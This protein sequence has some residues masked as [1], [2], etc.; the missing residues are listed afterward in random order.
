MGEWA[1]NKSWILLVLALVL[2]GG[3]AD[4]DTPVEP[5]PPTLDELVIAN[6]YAARDY[7]EAYADTWGR[8]PTFRGFPRY[9]NNPA[10]GNLS[11]PVDGFAVYPG[12]TG[13]IPY[14]DNSGAVGYLITSYG[15]TGEI[16][17]INKN[18]SD[19]RLALDRAILA[20]CLIV[21]SAIESFT[22]E[23]N[24]VYPAD[25]ALDVNLSGDT[26]RDLLPGGTLLDN[27]VTQLATEPVDIPTESPG[28][29]VYRST[30]RNGTIT[31]YIVSGWS[32]YDVVVWMREKNF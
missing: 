2:A 19:S 3:C 26:V 28:Q 24:G 16:F 9:L 1:M 8:Y 4:K 15:E 18:Y 30:R 14:R 31:N 6:C 17:S 20:N 21:Q 11:E 5:T 32:E 27:P 10:T 23:N 7:A 25:T 29:T 13:Y 12:Q 22:A